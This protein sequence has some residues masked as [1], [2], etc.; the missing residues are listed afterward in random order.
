MTLQEM[1]RL[2]KRWS[3]FYKQNDDRRWYVYVYRYPQSEPDAGKAFY[4]GKGC[5]ERVFNHLDLKLKDDLR[6]ERKVRIIQ[7]LK[8]RNLSPDLEILADNLSQTD[9]LKYETIAIDA[10]GVE[11]L[12]NIVHGHNSERCP[13]GL[14]AKVLQEAVIRHNMLGIKINASFPKYFP[15]LLYD[16]ED[17][18][19]QQ[20]L[21][22]C[23]TLQWKVSIERLENDK[24]DYYCA[25]YKGQILEVF[26]LNRTSIMRMNEAVDK[27]LITLRNNHYIVTDFNHRVIGVDEFEA[28]RVY[29]FGR[30]APD[31]IRELYLSKKVIDKNSQ[32]PTFYMYP[33]SN[34]K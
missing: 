6:E 4:I 14:S 33:K 22:E 13:I 23:T 18:E 32:I 21:Y 17:K 29:L 3:A 26:A 10:I 30:I 34:I 11:N 9:A 28:N 2:R 19:H 5:G 25:I 7:D 1:E 20:K 27:G 31:N 8:Q 16:S 15:N 12:T 24:I